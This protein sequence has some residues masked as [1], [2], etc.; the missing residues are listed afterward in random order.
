MIR[1]T[2][3]CLP[4]DF[5]PVLD[6]LN[7]DGSGFPTYLPPD[8]YGSYLRKDQSGG[9]D[10]PQPR[11]TKTKYSFPVE[12]RVFVGWSKGKRWNPKVGRPTRYKLYEKRLVMQTFSVRSPASVDASGNKHRYRAPHPYTLTLTGWQSSPTFYVSYQTCYGPWPNFTPYQTVATR[13]AGTSKALGS[14]WQSY[15]QN[16]TNNDDIALIG[17]LRTAIAGSEFNA[18]V[19]L[20]EGH[21]ALKMIT[22]TAT[23]LFTSYKRLRKGDL[24]GSMR[25]LG[26]L[27]NTTPDK[28]R[29]GAALRGNAKS[30]A[31]LW[32]E[33]QY[34]WKPLLADMKSGAEFLSHHLT[35]PAAKK[36][37]VRSRVKGDFVRSTNPS[38]GVITSDIQTRSQIIAYVE[39][40]NVALLAG[41][42]DPLGLAWELLPFS[43]IADWAFPIGAYLSARGLQN[44]V[45]GTYITTKTSRAFLGCNDYNAHDPMQSLGGYTYKVN[46]L[47]Q[48]RTVS[49]SL[50]IPSPNF[51]PF[52]KVA[53]WQHAANSIALLV[54]QFKS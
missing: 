31:N 48:V 54:Q 29:S 4:S 50:S 2:F 51:K 44:A 26:L 8:K 25:E 53:T 40:T 18:S 43:F 3:P 49:D 30:H 42:P 20:G 34:G 35:V 38:F 45:T 32:L 11:R 23:R 15:T 21:K 22:S 7:C 39:E 10:A 16:W 41:L 36:Y 52:G 17:K 24:T 46:D 9:D 5:V 37:V 28:I 12:R 33:M 13:L 14:P 6:T 19:F 27:G 1:T 47:T